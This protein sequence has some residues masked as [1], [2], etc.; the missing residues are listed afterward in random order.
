MHGVGTVTTGISGV[1]VNGRA[2]ARIGDLTSCGA[3]IVTGSTSAFEGAGVARKGDL[4]S[5]GG[6][7]DEGDNGW[8]FD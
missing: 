7:L 8:L 2:V 3:T 6:T 5:H 4:T 1:T